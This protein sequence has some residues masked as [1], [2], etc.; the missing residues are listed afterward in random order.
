MIRNRSEKLTGGFTAGGPLVRPLYFHLLHPHLALLLNRG[1]AELQSSNSTD[2]GKA[3]NSVH[4]NLRWN[5]PKS[6]VHVIT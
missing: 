3:T 5:N 2:K 1:G 6:N 4:L